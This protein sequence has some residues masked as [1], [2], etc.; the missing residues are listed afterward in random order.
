MRTPRQIILLTL[1]LQFCIMANGQDVPTNPERE[2]AKAAEFMDKG[3][4]ADAVP[5]LEALAREY[6]S[7]DIFW[8]LGISATEIH[9]TDKALK[10]WLAYR[11]LAPDDWRGRAKLVQAYQATGNIKARN[12]E[13]AE[14][15]RLWEKGEDVDLRKQAT[16]CREQVIEANRRV[17]V[18]EHFHPGGENMVVYSFEVRA[19]DT[20]DYRISLGSY[21]GT[22]QVG[23]ETGS[24]PR[25][26]R[27]YHL[28]LYRPKLHET[29]GFYEG[30]PS[31][32]TVRENVMS[33]LAGEAKPISSTRQQ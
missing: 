17:F 6:E 1:L 14:L 29:Y 21:E 26:V 24:R 27:L 3:Q 33:I 25:S 12:D 7:D 31:Y 22:N 5:I 28:D 16:F 11:T 20:E 18:L 9:A 4:F 30:Q 8:N 32:E 19:P 2:F 13:R 10:A 23:W 15:I